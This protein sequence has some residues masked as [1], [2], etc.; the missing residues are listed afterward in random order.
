MCAANLCFMTK[1]LDLSQL[2]RLWYLLHRRPAKAQAS[3]RIRAVSQ[4]PSLFDI[5]WQQFTK[6]T[7]DKQNEQLFPGQ[8]VILL[9]KLN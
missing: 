1:F 3:L 8:V 6:G 7:G 2:M 9:R 5:N 4:E